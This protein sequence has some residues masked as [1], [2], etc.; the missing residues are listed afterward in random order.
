MV[1]DPSGRLGRVIGENLLQPNPTLLPEQAAVDRAL[2][3]L[4]EPDSSLRDAAKRFPAS[5]AV[6]A[7]LAEQA[8]D[9][10]NDLEA[11]AFA[12]VGYHRGLDMLRQNGWRGHGP[13]PWSHAP[14]RGVL[15]SLHALRRSAEHIGETHEVARLTEFLNDADP[16]AIAAIEAERAGTA[17]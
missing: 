13:I 11:Y 12:R 16:S 17:S 15:R 14:N 6:W 7:A 3:E 8:F 1:S 9:A 10:G 5:P 2:A 4:S